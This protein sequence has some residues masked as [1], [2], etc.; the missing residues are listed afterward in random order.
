MVLF[1]TPFAGYAVR[2]S[3]FDESRLAVG[4]AQ[5]YG[6]IG[7]GKLH[8][9]QVREEEEDDGGSGL[10]CWKTG[11]MTSRL[12]LLLPLFQKKKKNP[13][14]PPS[15]PAPPL[16]GGGGPRGGRCVFFFFLKKRKKG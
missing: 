10:F 7:N 1:R 5:N 4:T 2:F 12:S 15:P 16:G 14:T 8:V 3:P 11:K 9:L 6:I 13:H